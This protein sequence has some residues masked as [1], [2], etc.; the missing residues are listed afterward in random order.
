MPPPPPRARQS[1]EPN[2]PQPPP[3]SQ[4]PTE[5]TTRYRAILS[6]RDNKQGFDGDQVAICIKAALTTTM[7]QDQ[8]DFQVIPISYTGPFVILSNLHIYDFLMGQEDFTITSMEGQAV[9]EVFQS[10]KYGNPMRPPPTP[11]ALLDAREKRKVTREQERERT[12]VFFV[13]H[14][15]EIAGSTFAKSKQMTEAIEAEFKRGARKCAQRISAV[16]CEK[17]KLGFQS[18]QH[19]VYVTLAQLP[20]TPT[21]PHQIDDLTG[22]LFQWPKLIRLQG[23]ATPAVT[24]MPRPQLAKLKVKSCCFRSECDICER[25][26]MC[27]SR[28]WLRQAR[29]PQVSSISRTLAEEAKAHR[30]NAQDQARA[31]RE[32]EMLA[33]QLPCT[34]V[35]K[36]C[37]VRGFSLDP[38]D[39]CVYL[40]PDRDFISKVQC[41]S[42]A[43][44]AKP[45]PCAFKSAAACPYA[46]HR[47]ANKA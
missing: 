43:A 33:R 32:R 13:A 41:T 31:E 45:K 19:M 47:D 10:D 35:N 5:E 21:T 23:V 34:F 6:N 1:E 40:H 16:F 26:G 36:G 9:F 15:I 20:Y 38:A 11:E 2:L 39:K 8:A 18:A 27:L 17:T 42:S 44:R 46:G 37:C 3:A 22:E 25:T 12:L 7:I 24:T 4:P 14:P 28:L 29:A 30:K